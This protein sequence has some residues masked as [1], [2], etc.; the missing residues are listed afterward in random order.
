MFHLTVFNNSDL[1]NTSY[2]ILQTETALAVEDPDQAFGGE[3][4]LRGAK[5]VFPRLS[6]K[7]C[8]RQSLC[9]THKRLLFVGQKV[10][11]FVGR[12]MRFYRE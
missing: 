2:Q 1:I 9:V 12:T 4:K 10:A 6:T 7:C 3:L 8:L 11:I 5:K